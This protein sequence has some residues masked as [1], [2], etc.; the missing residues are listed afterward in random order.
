MSPGGRGGGL[1]VL[2]L[3]TAK[4]R[5]HTLKLESTRTDV[6]GKICQSSSRGRR[7]LG[8]TMA[9]G[10]TRPSAESPPFPPSARARPA[11]LLGNSSRGCG[12]VLA[13]AH[14][15][16]AQ[17]SGPPSALCPCPQPPPA[18]RLPGGAGRGGAVRGGGG[19]V[20]SSCARAR[21]AGQLAEASPAAPCAPG[22]RRGTARTRAPGRR[23]R[24]RGGERG[25][26]GADGVGAR[27]PSALPW[28]S[29]PGPP[30]GCR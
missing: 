30:S 4:T 25:R 20:G 16:G 8:V 9:A 3:T 5:S 22:L 29:G 10:S 2:S 27:R 23:A 13:R 1:G 24:R 6:P 12:H 15:S 7:G 21:E 11:P 19:G 26:A 28:W 18:T 17:R 14:A